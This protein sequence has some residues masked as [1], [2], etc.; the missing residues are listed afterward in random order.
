MTPPDNSPEQPDFV[1]RSRVSAEAPGRATAYVRKHSFGVGKPLDFDADSDTISALEYL[2]GALGADLV[3]GF[4][5]EA[6]RQ[7]VGLDR[8]EATV[9][10]RLDNPLTHLN[11]VGESGHPG[12]A[13]ASVKVYASSFD[14]EESVQ[15][16]W[17]DALERSPLVHTLR[18]S[19]ELTLELQVVV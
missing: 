1:W 8:V 3:N 4:R 12:L 9:E 15:Q 17:T 5:A 11:V 14:P 13:E 6:K 7:R 2:L 19:V 18:G 16:V 10:G